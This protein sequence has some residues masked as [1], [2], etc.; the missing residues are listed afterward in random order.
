M[1]LSSDKVKEKVLCQAAITGDLQ[2]AD[3]CISSGVLNGADHWDAPTAIDI[4]TQRG[5]SRLVVKLS[6]ALDN[7]RLLSLGQRDANTVLIRVVGPPGAGKST[8]VKSLRTSRLRGF[9]RWERQPDEDD[10]NFQARTRGIQVDSYEDSNGT[11]CRILDLGGQ[12]DFA[13][14]NQLF[15]GEGQIPVINIITVSALKP[16][17]E[18]KEEVLQWSAF[19][20]SRKDNQAAMQE[21][22]LQPV[23]VAATRS[24]RADPPQEQNV[25]EAVHQADISFGKFLDFQHGPVFLDARKSRGRGIGELRCM[26]ADVSKHIL[27]RAPP[28]AALCNDIQRALPRIRANVKQPMI[29]RQDLPGLVAEGLS[30]KRHSFDKS[31]IQSHADLLAAALRQMSDACEILSF[32]TPGLQNVLIID[33]PWLLHDVIGALLSPGNFPPPCVQYDKNGR[34]T[35]KRVEAALKANFGSLL[36]HGKTLH[37]VV[38][39]GLCILDSDQQ[40]TGD[41]EDVIVPSKM[42]ISRNL[43]AVLLPGDLVAIWFGIELLCSEVP[44]SVCLF[45]QLQV[46]LHNYLL[47]HCKQKPIMWS[48]HTGGLAV[49][50]CHEH[51]MGIVEARR[52]RDGDRHH[53]ARN[54]NH[55]ADLLLFASSA[56]GA[57]TA[58]SAAVQSRL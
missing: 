48:G 43:H 25:R 12:E 8:L 38:E 30:T 22:A 1:K 21:P 45:P 58:E 13:S 56:E 27:N 57:D 4:A 3:H 31:V 53:C 47:Q 37:M 16:Y 9:F 26:L 28:Q 44:L 2:L 19:F 55:P 42:E 29:L 40:R 11:L 15:I 35:R 24:E 46:Y 52:S 10:K 33:P 54:G 23:I 20:A 41:D 5:H 34:A 32:D 7:H 39:I 18:M 14:A 6:K 50:L 17:S 36:D 51:V 49:A